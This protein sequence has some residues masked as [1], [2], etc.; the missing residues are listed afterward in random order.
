MSFSLWCKPRH[1]HVVSGFEVVTAREKR[2]RRR[3]DNDFGRRCGLCF[4]FSCV[5]QPDLGFSVPREILRDD[6]YPAR[7][8]CGPG[9]A[10]GTCCSTRFGSHL[11]TVY[12]ITRAKR[13]SRRRHA[14][15]QPAFRRLRHFC[16]T[17]RTAARTA[18]GCAPFF[19]FSSPSCCTCSL[20]DNLPV[21]SVA[22][23]VAARPSGVSVRV[24]EVTQRRW[25]VH[26]RGTREFDARDTE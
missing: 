24:P 19:L 18:V 23:F 5:C 11:E 12:E 25:V 17:L 6:R 26:R 14:L 15:L 8:V 13:A 2:R 4:H 1:H 16:L 20:G 7:R 3:S 10:G 21:K 22:G 9:S